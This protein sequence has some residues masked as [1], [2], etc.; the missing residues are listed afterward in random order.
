MSR[1]DSCARI[2]LFFMLFLLC[3]VCWTE[4]EK[5][6]E[7]NSGETKFN[8]FLR[9]DTTF[10]LL[11]NNKPLNYSTSVEPEFSIETL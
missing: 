11:M 5:N 6:W 2:S 1:I 8:D 9:I 4:L 3:P 7:Y 10:W